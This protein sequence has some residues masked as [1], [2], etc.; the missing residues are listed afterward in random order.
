MKWMSGGFGEAQSI[1]HRPDEVCNW[2]SLDI[3]LIQQSAG[4]VV[5]RTAQRGKTFLNKDV[6][7]LVLRMR[8]TAAKRRVAKVARCDGRIPTRKISPNY[9][10]QVLRHA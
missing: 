2:V 4:D 8:I 1:A 6:K 10:L 5:F 9:I 3:L 7:L